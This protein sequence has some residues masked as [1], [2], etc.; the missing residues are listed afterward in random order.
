V[1]HLAVEVERLA[2]RG[3]DFFAHRAAAQRRLMGCVA[4]VCKQH[5]ELVAPQTRH[6]VVAGHDLAQPLRDL[7][8]QRVAFFVSLGFVERLEVVNVEQQQRAQGPMTGS[9]HERLL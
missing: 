6:G 9:R 2:Q 4:Q 7:A 3:K 8:Q 1:V 5:G